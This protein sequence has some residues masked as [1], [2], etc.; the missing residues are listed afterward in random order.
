MRSS[1][2]TIAE[3]V[4]KILEE[5]PPNVLLEAAAKGRKP[6]EIREAIA[7]GVKIIGENYVQEAEAVMRELGRPPGVRWHFIG[8]LQRNK[9]KKAVELFDLIETVDSV[10]LA[11]E[12]EKRSARV[13]RTMPILIEINSGREPQKAGVLPEEAEDFIREI[14]KFPHLK[15]MGL[16]T[17]GPLVAEPE[18]IRP[19]FRATRELFERINE[20]KIP[21]VEMRLLSM[22]MSDTYRVA[23]EEGA[24]LVRIG[25]AIFGPR[26]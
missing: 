13:G 2:G 23:I 18:A 4:Q 12:L 3:N 6:E 17:M 20:L 15:V 26:E 24:N 7:A 22:G 1:V 9:A 16:M 10:K 21:N 11:A 25:T 8:H 19:Y 5:L 14:A